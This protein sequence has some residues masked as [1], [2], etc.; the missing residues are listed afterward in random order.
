MMYSNKLIA[1]VK[2]NGKVLREQGENV[3]LPFGQ[4]FTILIKNKNSLRALVK[5][6]ID[7]TDAT[8]GTSLIVPAN[9]EIE[10]ERFIKNGNLAQGNKFKFIERTAQIEQHRGAKV[11]DGFI[12]IEFEFEREAQPIKSPPIY[13][14]PWRPYDDKYRLI[15]DQQFGDRGIMRGLSGTPTQSL[16]N[17]AVAQAT[18][19]CATSKA[20]ATMDSFCDEVQPAVGITVPG[21][22]SDQK[23]TVGAWFATDGVKHV[24]IMRMFGETAQG[25]QVTK[26]VTV[27]AKPKCTTCGHTNK[28]NAKFCS[29]C[30]TSLTLV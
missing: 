24:M 2:S 20:A 26:P 15:G 10:I 13:T 7:G 14:T 27:K 25:V 9:G 22:V 3:F 29:N 28:A 21:A 19:Y 12:R 1:V 17:M 23:F 8:D 6:E 16:M 5:I 30:G 11:D 4:E 18:S